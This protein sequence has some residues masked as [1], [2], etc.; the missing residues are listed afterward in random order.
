ML[1]G[2]AV[3]VLVGLL[4]WGSL[5]PHILGTKEFASAL[6]D[7]V[8]I[9][10]AAP[11]MLLCAIGPGLAIAYGF[12]RRRQPKKPYGQVQ[13]VLWRAE[14]LVLRI[15]DRASG[16]SSR[17]AKLVIVGHARATYLRTWWQQLRE[18]ISRS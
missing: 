16:M 5:S 7:I 6:A 3:F 13:V 10:I 8:V 9:A 11:L 1:A 2:L 18:L 14:A 17:L 12:Y 15:Q 4:L